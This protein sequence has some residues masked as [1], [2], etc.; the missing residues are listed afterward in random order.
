MAALATADVGI[1]IGKA[2]SETAM[3]AADVVL[4]QDRWSSCH[5]CCAS[6]TKREDHPLECRTRPLC[7][8][9]FLLLGP[10]A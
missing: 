5:R 9:A 8:A 1:A 10:P 6:R 7:Q 2:G 4:M 3:H